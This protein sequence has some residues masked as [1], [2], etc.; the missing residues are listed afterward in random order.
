MMRESPYGRESVDTVTRR[1]IETI[2]NSE[3]FNEEQEKIYR[4]SRNA[5]REMG[6]LT[7]YKVG[8]DYHVYSTGT[9]SPDVPNRMRIE[10]IDP[11]FGEPVFDWHPHVLGAEPYNPS[12]ADLGASYRRGVPGVVSFPRIFSRRRQ[13]IYQ[14]VCKVDD[15][16]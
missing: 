9:P 3:K 8:D 12:P 15:Q 11:E 7:V 10:G 4:T 6:A 16:C 2:L 14:G 5:R 1:E 13:T